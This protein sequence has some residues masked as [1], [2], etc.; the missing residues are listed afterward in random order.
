MAKPSLLA[1]FFNPAQLRFL[2]EMKKCPR[3]RTF[4]QPAADRYAFSD[5]NRS[6]RLKTVGGNHNPAF[7]QNVFRRVGRRAFPS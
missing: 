4:M 7:W 1:E 3:K 2:P 6:K 5:K